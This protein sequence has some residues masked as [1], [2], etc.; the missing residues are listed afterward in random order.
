[1]NDE[2]I[3]KAEKEKHNQIQA[4]A[5]TDKKNPKV[6]KNKKAPEVVVHEEKKEPSKYE[7]EIKSALKFEK[8]KFRSKISNL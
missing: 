6:D 3:N 7:E 1:M 5:N 8:S 4:S 2:I